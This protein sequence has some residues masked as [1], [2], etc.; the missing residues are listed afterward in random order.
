M[1]NLPPSQGDQDAPGFEFRSKV[2]VQSQLLFL[3]LIVIYCPSGD[4]NVGSREAVMITK[5][6][7]NIFNIY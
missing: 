7:K 2:I 6:T 4:K 1:R 3:Y 5:Y